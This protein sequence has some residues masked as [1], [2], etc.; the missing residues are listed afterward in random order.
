MPTAYLSLLEKRKKQQKAMK[1]VAVDEV[2]RLV[3]LLR[4]KFRFE[5]LYLAGSLT[6]DAFRRNSD[7]DLIIKGLSIKDFFKAYALLLKESSHSIDFKPF[8]DLA[9]DFQKKIFEGGRRIG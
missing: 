1:E 7:L 6:T 9:P 8:E 3:S 4:K 2:K 5:S